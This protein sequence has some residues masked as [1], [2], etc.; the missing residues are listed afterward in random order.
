MRLKAPTR[1]SPTVM[2]PMLLCALLLP[3]IP[4]TAYSEDNAPLRLTLHRLLISPSSRIG[5]SNSRNLRW[6]TAATRRRSRAPRIS[7]ISRMS[8]LSCI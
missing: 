3:A 1:I 6:S 7:L 5:A 2:L 4:G 8:L